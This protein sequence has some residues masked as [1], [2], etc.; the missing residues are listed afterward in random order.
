VL[1]IESAAA[2]TASSCAT[3]QFFQAAKNLS[4]I[5]FLLLTI[6]KTARPAT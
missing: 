6:A 3:P 5:A 1:W 2:D 4:F